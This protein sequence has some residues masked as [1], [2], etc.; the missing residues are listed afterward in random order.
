MPKIQIS[1]TKGLVQATG[2]GIEIDIG[3]VTQATSITTGVTL[4]KT[5]GIITTQSASTAAGAEDEFTVTNTKVG[6]GS[7]VL[8][9]MI[10]YAG[11]L[12]TNGIPVVQVTDVSAGSF[13]VMVHNGHASNALS[14]VLKIGFL[15]LEAL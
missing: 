13:K 5:A 9:N 14:G 6:A 8:C 1:D 2:D 12:T 3:T 4:S 7:I 10:D 11:T 15:V